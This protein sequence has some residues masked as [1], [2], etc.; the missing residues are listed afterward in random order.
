LFN[1]SGE[2]AKMAVKWSEM[3]G[4]PFRWGLHVR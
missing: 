1:R 2:T 3:V 4:N